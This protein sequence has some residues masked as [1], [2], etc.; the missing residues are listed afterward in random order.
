M[1]YGRWRRPFSYLFQWAVAYEPST[2]CEPWEA[3]RRLTGGTPILEDEHGR[4]IF[5]KA[6]NT[7]VYVFLGADRFADAGMGDD[8]GRT[9]TLTLRR[10]F[11]LQFSLFRGLRSGGD[12]VG[13]LQAGATRPLAVPEIQD[14]AA[15]PPPLD[16]PAARVQQ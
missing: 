4:T 7:S 2:I 14:E 6:E 8:Q 13:E 16:R 11:E 12:L 1:W 3:E 9:P 15:T 10:L 5:G